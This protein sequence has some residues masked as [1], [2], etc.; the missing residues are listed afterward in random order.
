[1]LLVVEGKG[2]LMD[3]SS[4]VLLP[5]YLISTR[6][7]TLTAARKAHSLLDSKLTQLTQHFHK[8]HGK[9]QISRQE[10]VETHTFI[11]YTQCHG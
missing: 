5:Y 11:R 9:K 10:P 2:G 8:T 4:Y 7:W 1:M 3:C 6:A